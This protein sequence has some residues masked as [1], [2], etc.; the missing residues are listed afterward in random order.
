MTSENRQKHSKGQMTIEYTVMFVAIVA[1]I[2]FGA[3]H[4]ISP[5]VNRFFRASSNIINQSVSDI[6]T[7]F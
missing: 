2:I 7:R 6:E 4:F 3:T 1:V 5:S